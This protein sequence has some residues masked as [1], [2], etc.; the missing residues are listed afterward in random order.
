MSHELNI[1]FNILI[2]IKNFERVK[3]DRDIPTGKFVCR[4]RRYVKKT[5]NKLGSNL[6]SF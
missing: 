2:E 5:V 1:P 3:K 4:T 6:I